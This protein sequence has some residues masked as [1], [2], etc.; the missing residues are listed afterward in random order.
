KAS[1]FWMAIML[2]GLV[3]VVIGPYRTTAA[4]EVVRMVKMMVL[5]LILCQELNGPRRMLHWTGALTSGL[6]VN[7]ITGLVQYY[8][9][10]TLGLADLGEPSEEVTKTLAATSLQGV[11]VWRVGAFL[12]HPNV[13]GAFLAALLPLCIACFLLRGGKIYKAYYFSAFALGTGAL[14]ATQSRSGWIGFAAAFSCFMMVSICH[15]ALRHR[16]LIAAAVIATV[17]V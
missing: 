17:L 15:M 7:A 2:L 16:S 9:H 5:F 1:Y 8:F 14:I 12:I 11:E 4:H 13:F 6:I 3:T 10:L